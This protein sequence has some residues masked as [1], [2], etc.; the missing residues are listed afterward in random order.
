MKTK[1]T[2]ASI[3]VFSLII[4]FIGIAAAIGIASSSVISQK[5]A[6]NTASSTQSF[7]VANSGAEIFLN[8]VKNASSD[9]T[10]TSLG[11]TTGGVIR[12]DI[13]GERKYEITAFKLNEDDPITDCSTAISEVDRIKSVG[14][15]KNTNRAVEM[16]VAAGGY[17]T[18]DDGGANVYDI[19]HNG[20]VGVGGNK[21]K[22]FKVFSCPSCA[23]NGDLWVT[24]GTD[25]QWGVYDTGA[26]GDQ[27]PH[28]IFQWEGGLD[29]F[30]IA[31]SATDA[32][33]LT[34]GGGGSIGASSF[35][36][37]SD[38]RYK[39]DITSIDNS[40]EKINNLHGVYFNWNSDS[41]Y[42][43]NS[44]NIGF[45]AQDVEKIIPEVVFTGS[46]GYKSIEYGNLSAL[47]VEGIKQ[48]QQEID[49]LK[50][51][52][53]DLKKEVNNMHFQQR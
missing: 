12:G 2:K 31:G 30:G 26:N 34:V 6:I 15:Y 38:I 33:T 41:G 27:T 32:Y 47:L 9:T 10:L 4:L 46:N 3:L 50:N 40:L 14:S 39:K 22:D 37:V 7:Q 49:S 13:G 1:K 42:D 52:I 43:I 17:W 51:Q 5:S 48:Q 45:I 36:Q 25:N 53:Q 29:H 18:S 28:T 24:G 20:S 44:R 23:G 35:N 21:G 16:A 11:C 19:S 8:K